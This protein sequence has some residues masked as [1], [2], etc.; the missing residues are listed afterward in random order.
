M[1]LKKGDKVNLIK[2]DADFMKWFK[3]STI[4]KVWTTAKKLRYKLESKDGHILEMVLPN[5]VEEA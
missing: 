5:E 4:T 2:G 1:K 3:G